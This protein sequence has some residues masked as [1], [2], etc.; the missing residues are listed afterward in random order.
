[1]SDFDVLTDKQKITFILYMLRHNKYCIDNESLYEKFDEDKIDN[2][3]TIIHILIIE[4]SVPMP[5]KLEML[6]SLHKDH[7]IEIKTSDIVIKHVNL[8]EIIYNINIK[9]V[10]YCPPSSYMTYVTSHGYILKEIKYLNDPIPLDALRYRISRDFNIV[11]SIP[12]LVDDVDSIPDLDD[13]VDLIPDLVDDVDSIP[14]L[15]DD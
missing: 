7:I 13:D 3:T 4:S 6:K 1:M 14:D 9:I 11:D 8:C 10:R 12:D 5:C 2:L 15:V